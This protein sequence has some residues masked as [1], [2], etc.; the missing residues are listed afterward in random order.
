M[1]TIEAFKRKFYVKAPSLLCPLLLILA[2][3]LLTRPVFSQ[4]QYP[5]EYT[6]FFTK[7]ENI[8]LMHPE[9]VRDVFFGLIELKGNRSTARSRIN[10]DVL[11]CRNYIKGNKGC[12]IKK[13][14]MEQK[15]SGLTGSLEIPVN[16]TYVKASRHTRAKQRIHLRWRPE[17]IKPPAVSVQDFLNDVWAAKE[18][19]YFEIK[20]GIER[21][22][23]NPVLE[24]DIYFITDNRMANSLVGVYKKLP[25]DRQDSITFIFD[26]SI[27]T[28]RHITMD[29]FIHLKADKVIMNKQVFYPVERKKHW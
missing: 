28:K 2:L 8:F 9:L 1:K 21:I 15:A 29:F 19:K 27:P 18:S 22:Q 23:L 12:R 16:F 20:K 10:S 25:T 13:L 3:V 17:L 5:I 4:E 7:A 6:D 14:K 11:G 26:Y 24:R